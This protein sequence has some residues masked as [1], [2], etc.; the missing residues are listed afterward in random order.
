MKVCA[1]CGKEFEPK[2]PLQAT[3]CH[4]CSVEHNRG[5]AR[6][7]NARIRHGGER[8]KQ[9][10]CRRCGAVFL[11][12]HPNL[13]YCPDCKAEEERIREELGCKSFHWR[14]KEPAYKVC[15]VCGAEFET[16]DYRRNTCSPECKEKRKKDYQK[17]YRQTPCKTAEDKF[18]EAYQRV[19]EDPRKFDKTLER[20]KQ[21]G[22]SYAEAQREETINRYARIIT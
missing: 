6:K 9:V 1:V 2:H 7:R 21:E 5:I 17:L 16:T 22:K 13:R 10:T 20:L 4:E 11:P 19:P 15:V 18:I 8:V 14:K 12:A 3:C